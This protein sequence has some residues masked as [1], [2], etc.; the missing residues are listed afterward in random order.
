MNCWNMR[1]KGG[2]TK[3]HIKESSYC[4]YIIR[5]VNWLSQKYAENYSDIVS[6]VV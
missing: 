5:L 2:R 1:N 3:Q 6:S 4:I